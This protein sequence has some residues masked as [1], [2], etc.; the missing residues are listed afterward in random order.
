MIFSNHRCEIVLV[1]E[2]R[3]VGVEE[4]DGNGVN[5]DVAIERHLDT[6]CPGLPHAED[7]TGAH[8]HAERLGIPEGL[9]LVV[10]RVRL[11]NL[12]VVAARGLEAVVHRLHAR[13]LQ[14][15]GCP[16]S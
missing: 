2:R 14:A 10:I 11:D 3:P 7:A 8:I 6:A 9:H 12:I 15:R 1:R 13:G 4:I 16:C 5:I